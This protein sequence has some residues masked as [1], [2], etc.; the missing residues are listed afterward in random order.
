MSEIKHQLRKSLKLMRDNYMQTDSNRYFCENAFLASQ[1]YVNNDIFLVYASF[2]SEPDTFL[3]IKRMLNDNKIVYLPKVCNNKMFFYKI[4]SL[5]DLS[6]GYM[7]IKEPSAGELYKNQSAVCIVPG[8]AFDKKGGRIGY[9]KGY[10]DRFLIDKDLVKV[11]FCA[12][13]N[14]VDD[15]P[16]E[17]HDIKMDYIIVNDKIIKL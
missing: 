5:E 6:A 14:Y 12:E 1:L 10:Y 11:G 8:L 7:T 3:L 2:R 4:D 9:G 16:T 17:I 13:C 15:I